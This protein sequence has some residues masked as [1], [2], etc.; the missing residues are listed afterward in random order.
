[1]FDL[2]TF[3][4][5]NSLPKEMMSCYTSKVASFCIDRHM[6]VNDIRRFIKDSTNALGLAVLAIPYRSPGIAV[7]KS[8]KPIMG[9]C[10]G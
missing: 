2:T 3:K 9:S 1:M 5:E 6:T 10:K 4:I 8:K 7:K